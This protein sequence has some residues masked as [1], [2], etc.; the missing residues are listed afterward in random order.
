[1]LFELFAAIFKDKKVLKSLLA[2]NCKINLQIP[3]TLVPQEIKISTF[4]IWFNK[5]LI[6]SANSSNY[7]RKKYRKQANYLPYTFEK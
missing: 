2:S 5:H 7:C 3:Q 4:S 6:Y 1:V